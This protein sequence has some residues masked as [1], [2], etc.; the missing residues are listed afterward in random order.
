MSKRVYTIGDCS[1]EDFYISHDDSGD[2]APDG[3][4]TFETLAEAKEYCLNRI[5][6]RIK[7]LEIVR[8]QIDKTKEK[9]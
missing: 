5:D 8:Q 6:R 1:E 7:E 9:A 2:W 3:E 4:F